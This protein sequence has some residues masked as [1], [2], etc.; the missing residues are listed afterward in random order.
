MTNGQRNWRKYQYY[1]L[2]AVKI[3]TDLSE[4]IYKIG[5]SILAKKRKKLKEK[6]LV[7]FS[8]PSQILCFLFFFFRFAMPPPPSNQYKLLLLFSSIFCIA[9]VSSSSATSFLSSLHLLLFLLSRLFFISP[10]Y[11]PSFSNLYDLNI[12]PLFHLC[13]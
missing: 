1:S 13:I 2:R 4:L 12:F 8:F 5:Y 3:D 7:I 6:S 10:S 9:I 11:F